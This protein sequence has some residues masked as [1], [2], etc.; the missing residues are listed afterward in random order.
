ML[1][2]EWDSA[3]AFANI[4]KHSVTFDEAASAFGDTLSLTVPDPEHSEGEYRYLLLGVSG[5]GRLVVVSHTERSGRIRIIGARPAV[6]KE[7][8][9]YEQGT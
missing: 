3:K 1:D 7:R 5:T 6:P 4:E 8:R 9:D 2:F